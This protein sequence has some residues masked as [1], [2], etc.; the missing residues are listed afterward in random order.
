MK[1]EG[2]VA[3]VTGGA[4]GLGLGTVVN[5]IEGGA[6]V[7]IW[8]LNQSMG[9]ELTKKLKVSFI[10]VDVSDNS[11][12]EQAFHQTLELHGQVDILVNCAGVYDFGPILS[13]S[14]QQ[15]EKA[16]NRVM[17]VN[18]IGT[19]NC[20]RT[21]AQHMAYKTTD[22]PRGVIINTA[23]IAGHYGPRGI[24]IYGASKGAILGMN[25][26]LARDLGAY[27]IRV[28]SISPGV[29]DTPMGAKMPQTAKSKIAK[30]ILA[31]RL[32]KAEEYG[33]IARFLV[34]NEYMTGTDVLLDG[35]IRL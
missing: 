33:H 25:I 29:F 9:D 16:F 7:V 18:V 30:T 28:C 13:R 10:R 27:K 23:S 31:G 2:S 17:N 5:F 8:D 1:L 6:K 26:A 11:S 35:G 32:G 21:V 15:F 20:C 34:E 24:S 4:S 22:G 14:Q 19:F 3:I 12:V